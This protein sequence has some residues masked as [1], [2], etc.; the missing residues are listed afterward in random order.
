M[1]VQAQSRKVKEAEEY[2]Y[3]M[4]VIADDYANEERNTRFKNILASN[5]CNSPP[6]DA[7]DMLQKAWNLLKERGLDVDESYMEA[8]TSM[9]KLSS[10][11]HQ[12]RKKMGLRSNVGRLRPDARKGV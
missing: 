2:G 3:K 1:L 6:R 12:P 9:Y 8:I 5:D 4:A 10:R 7:A 11:Q